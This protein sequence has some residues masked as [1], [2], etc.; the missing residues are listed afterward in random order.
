VKDGM[1]RL[2][3]LLLLS[4]LGIALV[5]TYRAFESGGRV[6]FSSYR[7]V[8]CV[9]ALVLFWNRARCVLYEWLVKLVLDALPSCNF[10]PAAAKRAVK[11]WMQAKG[12][13][14]KSSRQRRAVGWQA[15]AFAPTPRRPHRVCGRTPAL[16]LL[17]SLLCAVS[18][19]VAGTSADL[20]ARSD[21]L[22]QYALG[23]HAAVACVG[24]VHPFVG[25]HQPFHPARYIPSLNNAT[26]AAA[27]EGFTPGSEPTVVKDEAYTKD[28]DGLWTWGNHP[29]FTPD[30]MQR[31]QEAVRKRKH[32]FAYSVN[33][34]PGYS[35]KEPPFTIPLKHNDPIFS[36]QRSYSVIEQEIREEKMGELRDAGI[37][38]RAPANCQYASCPHY[39]AKRDA[40]GNWTDKRSTVDFRNINAH[41]Q[42]DLYGLHRIEDLFDRVTRAKFFTKIDLRSGFHQIPV[43]PDHRPKTAFWWGNELWQY[44]RLPMGL[45][46]SPAHFQR[47]MDREIQEAGLTGSVAC[48]IDDLLIYSD[49]A[50]EHIEHVSRML[51]RLHEVG[52]RAHPGK[53][54]FGA[55]V[56]EFLGHNVSYTGIHPTTAKVLAIRALRTPTN[57]TEL[58]SV[59]GLMNYYR[60]FVP[61]YSVLQQ[62]L[63]ELLKKGAAWNWTAEHQQAYDSLKEALCK[64]GNALKSFDP[65]LPTR[66]YTDWS[67]Q[68]IG[69]VL[70]QEHPDGN[71]YLVACISRSL[72]KAEQMSFEARWQ[73]HLEG[74]LVLVSC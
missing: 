19:T 50:E 3:V 68:G 45:K 73:T 8:A 10:S 66:L 34:L 24:A 25:S 58:Q 26:A 39:P 20:F 41:T 55:A 22:L 44:K 7:A 71:E 40:N 46:S 29:E 15:S 42:P 74:C 70:A 63:N 57:V 54:I 33:D 21:A 56:I 6:F 67:K 14:R 18:G 72:N 30:Q 52:L 11:K 13:L 62:P 35:G 28:A 64:P 37:I 69:A 47:V 23:N 17:C 65:S 53:S 32:C 12:K 36:K 9:A 16:L 48:F 59:L 27:L 2:L 61:N 5:D 60:R 31:L 1:L 38:E 49:T 43:H 4:V 51:D